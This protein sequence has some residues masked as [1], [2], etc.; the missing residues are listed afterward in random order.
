ML[1][2]EAYK[3]SALKNISKEYNGIQEK[4]FDEK[5][6]EISKNKDILKG[7]LKKEILHRYYYQDGI[8]NHNIKNDLFIKEA[9][10]LLDNQEKY[11]AILSKN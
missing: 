11:R 1:F 6:N 5:I 7:V 10:N 4:L 2:K 9:V 3:A 8:Y